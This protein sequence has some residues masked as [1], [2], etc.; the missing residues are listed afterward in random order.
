MF[1]FLTLDFVRHFPVVAVMGLFLC[2][3]LVEIFGAKNKY[4]R[5]TITLIAAFGAFALIAALIKPVLIDGN[6]LAY[7]MGNWEPVSGYA[8]GIG[9]EID[10]LNMFFALLVVTT[11]LLA[12]I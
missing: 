5:N 11:I 2:A 12:A 6:V 9:Y 4:I 7:W 3:F 1:N 10:A 8:I